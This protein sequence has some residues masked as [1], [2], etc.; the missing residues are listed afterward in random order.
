MAIPQPLIKDIEDGKCIPFIGSGF[1]MNAIVR[2]GGKM[3]DWSGLT[4]ALAKTVGLSQD[5]D[6]PSVASA[7]EKKFG[8][9]QLIEAI[10]QSLHFDCVEP[11]DAHMAFAQLPFDTIYTTNF[12]L[13]LEDSFSRA[14]RPFHTIVGEIQMSF[15]GGPWTTSIVKMHGDLRHQEHVIVTIEDY[16]NYLNNYPFIATH[17]SAQLITKT[18]LF[19]GYS[20]TDPDLL[21][22]RRVV[23]SR[24]GK[25]ERMAYIIGFDCD[26][27]EIGEKLKANLHVINLDTTHG[28]S[29]TELLSTFFRE[30]QER[31]DTREG[32]KFRAAR[33]D[34]FENVSADILARSAR[35]SD[36]FSLFASSSNLCYVMMPSTDKMYWVYR[37]FI[38]PVAEQFGLS[39]VRADG[40]SVSGAIFEQARVA[41]QQSRLCIADVSQGN[42]NVLYEVGIARAIG[43]PMLL[44]CQNMNDVPFELRNSLSI[45]YDAQRIQEAKLKLKR[46]IQGVLGENRL[47]EV[48]RLI[49]GGM[50]RAAAAELGVI[51]EHSLRHL[52]EKNWRQI[53]LRTG[54][55]PLGLRR[56]VRL[57]A[58]SEIIEPD[59]I[60][61]L[62][63]AVDIR[64]RAVH[65]LQEPSAKDVGTMLQV[66]REFVKK[67]L[68][69]T[70][71]NG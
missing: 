55:R 44:L 4:E 53:G 15:H 34:V 60:P 8:R 42:P 38:K 5:L 63:R 69:D 62:E 29:K 47:T 33:P 18:A 64:N 30:I 51:L 58:E 56:S 21:N 54:Q 61:L 37:D 49:N 41:I 20:L 59:D 70:G 67:Y 7:F 17:L 14:K 31:I 24:L 52:Q 27:R 6:G 22:I 12:D 71:E 48:T 9:V 35:E 1:S 66:V 16:A 10:R 40:I 3:P 68:G 11:G 28:S 45:V 39:V 65:E 19:L 13:L 26:P 25:Y 36:A 2:D 23:K 57:L 50:H 46:A 43:K 32:A